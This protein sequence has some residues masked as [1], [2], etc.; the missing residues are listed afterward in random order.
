MFDKLLEKIV[1]KRLI[2]NPAF[3]K[4][5]TWV[6][7]IALF[8]GMFAF[9][10][11]WFYLGFQFFQNLNLLTD[12]LSEQIQRQIFQSWK[13]VFYM[14]IGLTV[15]FAAA[16]V[17]LGLF[18]TNRVAGPIFRIDLD[19]KNMIKAGEFKEISTRK[20]DFFKDHL[21]VINELLKKCLIDKKQSKNPKNSEILK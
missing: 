5:A 6:F 11:C 4:E 16:T 9:L 20:S 19:L 21:E 10:A 13:Q 8:S 18:F 12:G 3:Q 7:L 15:I 2:V 14:S 17:F 1:R